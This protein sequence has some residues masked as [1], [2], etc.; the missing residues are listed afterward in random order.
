MPQRWQMRMAGALP[1]GTDVS[2]CSWCFV[3]LGSSVEI[4][5]PVVVNENGDSRVSRKWERLALRGSIVCFVRFVMLSCPL[6]VLFGVVQCAL[7]ALCAF[8]SEGGLALSSRITDRSTRERFEPL[9]SVSQHF[10]EG[11]TRSSR[12]HTAAVVRK[13]SS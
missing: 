11:T 4:A 7:S 5:R 13:M 12:V 3:R 6:C 9:T 1:V 10:N 8:G 2:S